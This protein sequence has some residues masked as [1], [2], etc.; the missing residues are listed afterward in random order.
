MTILP[1]SSTPNLPIMKGIVT[2]GKSKVI[3]FEAK[4]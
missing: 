4:D 1:Y 3:I 2:N